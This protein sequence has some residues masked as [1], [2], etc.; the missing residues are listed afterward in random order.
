MDTERVRGSANLNFGKIEFGARLD[1]V[2]LLWFLAAQNA[3]ALLAEKLL[4]LREA[5][6]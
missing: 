1:G 6:N 3:M 5:S 2:Y 4:K